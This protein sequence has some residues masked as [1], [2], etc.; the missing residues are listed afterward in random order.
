MDRVRAVVIR[1][2]ENLV[3][4]LFM[5][6]SG[7]T[8]AEVFCRYALGFSLTWSHE[9]VILLLIWI[10]WLCVPIGLER[11]DHLAVTVLLDRLSERAQR[12]LGWVNWALALFFVGFV[13]LLSFPVV[14]AFEGMWLLTVPVPT[15]A[16]YYAA[17]VGSFL[18]ALV[19]LSRLWS[20]GP[21][22]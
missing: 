4:V 19:L 21:G 5:A 11:G 8:L 3:G 2:L 14:D 18:S 20:R 10:V 1:T 7:V 6:I 15:N 13:F 17:T 16:R 12:R 9:V 22:P